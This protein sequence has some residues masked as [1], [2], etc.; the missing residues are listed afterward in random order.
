VSNRVT[1]RWPAVADD[2]KPPDARQPRAPLLPR[3][4]CSLFPG[5]RPRSFRDVSYSAGDREQSAQMGFRRLG[6]CR[7]RTA[8][9]DLEAPGASGRAV[10]GRSSPPAT[11]DDPW[12]DG[13]RRPRPLVPPT[14]MFLDDQQGRELRFRAAACLSNSAS[15]GVPILPP[16]IDHPRARQ[17]VQGDRADG[18]TSRFMCLSGPPAKL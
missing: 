16:Q 17:R 6:S 3:H 5:M 10:S 8:P 13:C 1:G 9:R 12:D 18:T 15:S 11:P 14:A 4:V 7:P 2:G